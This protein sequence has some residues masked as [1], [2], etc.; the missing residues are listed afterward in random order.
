LLKTL[1][2]SDGITVLGRDRVLRNL[3]KARNTVVDYVQ[4]SK[5][6][7]AEFTKLYMP[8]SQGLYDDV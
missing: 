4:L 2:K 1:T 6:Q 5:D 8:E 3:N 7:V